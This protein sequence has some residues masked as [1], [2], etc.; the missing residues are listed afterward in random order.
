MA[1]C[2]LC[3]R[4]LAQ[5]PL[6]IGSTLP[7]VVWSLPPEERQVRAKVS[8]DLCVL[9][10][11][12]FFLRAIALVP[13]HDSRE[14]FGWGLWA[15]VSREQFDRYVEAFNDDT[16][17]ADLSA[18]IANSPPMLP[19]LEGHAVT[20]TFHGGTAR[21]T[22]TLAASEHVLFTEQQQGISAARLHQLIGPAPSAESPADEWPF[23]VSPDHAA[24]TTSRV[25]EGAPVLSVVHYA[26]D[27]MWA[28][29]CSP[30]PQP[31]ECKVVMMAAIL[32]RFPSL[33][34]LADLPPG[35]RATRASPEAP[36]ERRRDHQ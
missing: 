33:V 32:M 18:T 13:V 3:R 25:L 31:S 14:P 9:D 12:R 6:D 7:D 20:V 5:H 28:F 17:L 21:P 24:L 34:E 23:A 2:S 1:T 8:P 22:L 29:L 36:W 16:T 11:E 26:D 35:W 10:G 30:Q 4:E 27:G 19:P 15:E